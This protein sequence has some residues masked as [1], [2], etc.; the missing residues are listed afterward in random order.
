MPKPDNLPPLRDVIA[1]YGLAPKKSLGQNFLFDLNL[2]RKI[3]RAAGA[4]EGGVFYEVGPGPGGL[5]RAL[6]SEGAHKVIVVE[7]DARCLPALEEIA[8]AWPGKLQ[9]ISADAL[10]LDE[11]MTLP[12]GVRMAANLPYNVG[13]ALLI[14]WLTAETW[15]PLWASLTLMFQKEVAQRI[16]AAPSS[17]HYGRLSVLAQWR[18][19]AK[20]LFDVNRG[21]FVPPPS[22]TSA[23]VRLEPRAEPLA[24]ASLQDLEKVTAAAFGQRRKMLRQSLKPLGGEALLEKAG[25][26]PTARLHPSA[27]VVPPPGCT[28]YPVCVRLSVPVPSAPISMLPKSPK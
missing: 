13:T 16:T 27:E 14:K 1:A 3:A 8:R 11:A 24:P 15:P 2:T 26:D 19:T 17:E 20:I 5:T 28:V 21:A 7:R 18:C 23:I 9:V 4:A 10:A 22:V 6:L 12:P 25:I